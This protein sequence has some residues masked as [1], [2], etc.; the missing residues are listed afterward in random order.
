MKYL[1]KLEESRPFLK[2]YNNTNI[3]G[4]EINRILNQDTSVGSLKELQDVVKGLRASDSITSFSHHIEKKVIDEANTAYQRIT[5]LENQ[6][7]NQQDQ[8]NKFLGQNQNI[9]NTKQTGNQ[10]QCD[11][12]N[13]NIQET[14]KQITELR[15]KTLVIDQLKQIITKGLDG[16]KS[17]RHLDLSNSF[18]K[19]DLAK[20]LAIMLEKNKDIIQLN[21]ANNELTKEGGIAICQG[22]NINESLEYLNLSHNKLPL[23]V[24]D[25]L[26]KALSTNKDLKYLSLGYNQQ[27][28]ALDASNYLSAIINRAETITHLN[29][30]Y[31]GLGNAGLK[32]LLDSLTSYTSIKDLNIAGNGLNEESINSLSNLLQNEACNLEKLVISNNALSDTVFAKLCQA[33]KTNTTVKELELESVGASG[34]G[35][36]EAIALFVRENNVIT[37]LRIGKNAIEYLGT[38]KIADALKTNK[39][40]QSVTMPTNG[41][42][43]VGAIYIAKSLE[44]NNSL[45]RLDLS[46]NAI[47]SAGL[48]YLS[49][50]LE[51][52]HNIKHLNL[53]KNQI[54]DN[55][56]EALATVL[57]NIRTLDLSY[58]LITH[59]GAKFLAQGLEGSPMRMLILDYNAS[60]G[61]GGAALVVESLN[62]STSLHTLGIAGINLQD[63]GF[64][65]L[66]PLLADNICIS[67]LIL[68]KNCFSANSAAIIAKLITDNKLITSL[69]L[70]QSNFE[71]KLHVTGN[72]PVKTGE[73]LL[74]ESLPNSSV[75]SLKGL[76]DESSGI[77]KSLIKNIAKFY[78]NL[79]A[80]DNLDK[81]FAP[82]ELYK[83]L[84]Q[85]QSKQDASA[86]EITFTEDKESKHYLSLISKHIAKIKEAKTVEVEESMDVALSLDNTCL[87]ILDNVEFLGDVEAYDAI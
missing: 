58:N 83:L 37:S 44:F 14:R 36:G 18:M 17:V 41:L 50:A 61:S 43:E 6:L 45:V 9:T 72:D 74:I 8:L 80:L 47:Q 60:I 62:K 56:I 67:K 23:E 73:S 70:G 2:L 51:N 71:Q 66:A 40:L 16:N 54:T 46:D 84:H 75:I 28:N 85:L 4:V 33:L 1:A 69:S 49:A 24:L 19:D 59:E 21:I 39:S 29:L 10:S 27:N 7:K 81:S 26:A 77:E 11:I 53:S 5:Y 52:N 79:R 25:I 32:I 87:K 3:S 48:I 76:K 78:S 64:K 63:Q 15:Q 35:G 38:K 82:V 55:G 42:D 20:D 13:K 34:E 68:D 86:P 30:E 57:S 65:T 31:M 22:L 12:Y